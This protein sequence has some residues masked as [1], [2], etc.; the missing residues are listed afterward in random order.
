MHS[1]NES[2]IAY[3]PQTLTYCRH[4]LFA[5][6]TLGII[7]FMI[8]SNSFN[9]SWHFDDEHTIT[10]NPNI[11]MKDLSWDSLK[12]A[13][14]SDQ[15]HPQRIYR[16]VSC[17]SFALNYYLGGLDVSGYH[18][19]NIS[20]H[21]ITAVFLFLFIYQTLN[22]P[23]LRDRY[24]E[25]AYFIA[26]FSTVL[27][28]INPV[29]GQAVTYIVQ[30]MASMAGMFYIMSMYLYLK[31]RTA[32]NNL[33]RFIFYFLGISA[34]LLGLGS[35]ENAV[36][37]PFSLALFEVFLLQ[38][39]P[40][41][42]IRKHIKTYLIII[43]LFLIAGLLYVC[44]KDI[45]IFEHLLA[46]YRDRPFTLVQRLLTETRIIIF[47]ISL[48]LYPVSTRLNIAH[49]TDIS[50]SLFTPITTVISLLLITGI[51]VLALYKSKKYPLVA[52]SICF[53]FLNHIVESSFLPLELIYEHR[54]YIPSMFFFLPLVMGFS[55]IIDYYGARKAMQYIL[56]AFIVLYLVG[57]G[58]STFIRNFTWKH[59]KSLWI[60]AIEKAPGLARSHHNLGR[61]YHDNGYRVEAL[62]EYQK[63]LAGRLAHRKSIYFYTY[64]NLGKL[65]SDQKD[66]VKAEFYYRKALEINPKF[67]AIYINLASIYDMNGDAESA[68][69]YIKKA[70]NLYP[71]NPVTNLNL[72]L[73]YIKIDMPEKAIFH[74]ERSSGSGS[75]SRQNSYMGIAYKQ[76]GLSGKAIIF[77]KE[78]IKNEPSD[79][80]SY[81]HMA[82]IYSK[83]GHQ[84]KAKKAVEKALSLMIG[85]E[86]RLRETLDNLLKRT[87]LEKIQPDPDVVLPLIKEAIRNTEKELDS[88][89]QMEDM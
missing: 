7:V 85:H 54:N 80:M 50:T 8:Y 64:Y 42:N 51:I 55:A 89:I 39:T 36:M 33:S 61:Y 41:L 77:F 59:P 52:F 57:L 44:L 20:I 66:Y 69:E 5:F 58:H 81:L 88:Y 2:F 84:D 29:Q 21:F 17:L 49:D 83:K 86:S 10:D 70:F 13:F 32:E 11:H 24:A 68:Y 9:C 65:F 22:L 15:N 53:F 62:S 6:I 34:F 40:W 71:N 47:Y 43:A 82:E 19:V 87:D 60:D 73:Y 18:L 74:L 37:V 78:A 79:V 31:A 67:P 38:E 63:A 14:H 27:W 35:K 46:G 25:K 4:V 45:N 56:L 23:L 1:G 30:R 16:P 76:K 72:G 48:L 28:A 3:K 12:R 26:L 75:S